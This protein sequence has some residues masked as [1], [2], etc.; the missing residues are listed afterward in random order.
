[1]NDTA[2]QS[3]P[4]YQ[5]WRVETRGVETSPLVKDREMGDDGRVEEGRTDSHEVDGNTKGPEQPLTFADNPHRRRNS[6]DALRQD[7]PWP[8]GLPNMNDCGSS[9]SNPPNNWNP[10]GQKSDYSFLRIKIDVRTSL[11]EMA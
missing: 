11:V 3:K 7:I 5:L 1:M 9:F 10:Q 4:L 2:H 6:F 8:G